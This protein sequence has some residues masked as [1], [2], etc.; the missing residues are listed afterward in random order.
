MRSQLR[1]NLARN[2]LEQKKGLPAVVWTDLLLNYTDATAELYSAEA[3]VT[4]VG[5]L[6]RKEKRRLGAISKLYLTTWKR[7]FGRRH[8][9]HNSSQRKALEENGLQTTALRTTSRQA[10]TQPLTSLD[11]FSKRSPCMF[12]L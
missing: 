6:P 12:V 9:L 3:A 10:E 5:R 7:S 4:Y 11:E 2:W 8:R 1:S